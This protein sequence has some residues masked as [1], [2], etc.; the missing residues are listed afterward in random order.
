MELRRRYRVPE[1][2][3]DEMLLQTQGKKQFPY[4]PLYGLLERAQVQHRHATA[5]RVQL[6]ARLSAYSMREL[7]ELAL[8]AEWGGNVRVFTGAVSTRLD[9]IKQYIEECRDSMHVHGGMLGQE[10]YERAFS[11]EW[12]RQQLDEFLGFMTPRV[13]Q[14]MGYVRHTHREIVLARDQLRQLAHAREHYENAR[15]TAFMMA[16]HPRLGAES[17][18]GDMESDLLRRQILGSVYPA[19]FGG[20]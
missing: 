4:P 16:T 19:A 12:A 7:L 6:D 2:W 1:D 10:M 9:E 14:R 17:Q 11:M 18:A 15:A 20:T 3:T 8:R 5:A 13:A